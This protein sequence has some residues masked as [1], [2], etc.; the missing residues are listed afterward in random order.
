M[1]KTRRNAYD[2][3][4]KCKA[5]DLAVGKGNKAAARELGLNESMIRRWKQQCDELTKKT[6]KAFRGKKSRRPE[7]ENELED[8]VNIQRADGRDVSTVQIRLKAKTITPR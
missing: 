8:W 2:V 5:I 4:F 1:A 7:L 6:T 3:A